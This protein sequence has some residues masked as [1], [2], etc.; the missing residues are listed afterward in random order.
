MKNLPTY[1]L[2]FLFISSQINGATGPLQTLSKPTQIAHYINTL[3][4]QL[5]EHSL[6]ETVINNFII[7][8][9]L[10]LVFFLMSRNANQEQKQQYQDSWYQLTEMLSETEETIR[11]YRHSPLL[12]KIVQKTAPLL[13]QD[14]IIPTTLSKKKIIENY[15]R[16]VTTPMNVH[17][18]IIAEMTNLE[19][20]LK[21]T[22]KHSINRGL[23]QAFRPLF[24][25]KSSRKMPEPSLYVQALLKHATSKKAPA[26]LYNKEN[27][28]PS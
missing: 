17:A 18:K 1:F 5:S 28:L 7:K 9:N 11:L 24:I 14:S 21:Q 16:L 27:T 25:K 26:N 15:Q 13:C 20:T 8:K 19:K 4:E 2:F 3:E 6:L 22:K 23:G 10:E 12:K